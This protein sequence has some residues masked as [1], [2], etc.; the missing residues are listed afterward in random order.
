VGLTEPQFALVCCVCLFRK[1]KTVPA[2]TTVKGYRVC[3]KHLSF[4]TNFFRDWEA[5]QDP[6]KQPSVPTKDKGK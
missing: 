3:K 4:K 1:G 5:A 2:V 6:S